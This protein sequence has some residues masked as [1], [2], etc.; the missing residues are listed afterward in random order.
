MC[1]HSD[2][3]TQTNRIHN[4]AVNFTA[5]QNA[6][7]TLCK[8]LHESFE[9]FVQRQHHSDCQRRTLSC[10]TGFLQSPRLTRLSHD[11]TKSLRR[12]TK[13]TRKPNSGNNNLKIHF[14]WFVL[15]F[16]EIWD[17]TLCI[18][19]SKHRKDDFKVKGYYN[20]P[21]KTNEIFIK[22]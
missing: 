18:T 15:F 14:H 1:T 21:Q 12:D 7:P 19:P 3:V 8:L 11:W 22:H 6:E 20:T 2:P 16:L 17:F 5:H 4:R 9:W 13:T 10:F